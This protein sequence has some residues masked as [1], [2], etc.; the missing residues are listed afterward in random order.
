[1]KFLKEETSGLWA[2]EQVTLFVLMVIE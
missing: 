2:L 1:V